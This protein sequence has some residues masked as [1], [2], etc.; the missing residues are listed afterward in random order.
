MNNLDY[1][2]VR[3]SEDEQVVYLQVRMQDAFGVEPPQPPDHLQPH[4]LDVF[5]YWCFF[6]FSIRSSASFNILCTSII[7]LVSKFCGRGICPIPPAG[8]PEYFRFMEFPRSN[9]IRLCLSPRRTENFKFIFKR[10]I[11]KLRT[12]I[13]KFKLILM[14]RFL[15]N[16]YI[17]FL[18]CM[19]AHTKPVRFWSA[20]L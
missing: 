13:I 9:S 1:R 7:T 14:R 11:D 18:I 15:I 5:W 4:P 8:A 3:P 6:I 17:S 16:F 10:V 2:L 19:V 12:E 20:P